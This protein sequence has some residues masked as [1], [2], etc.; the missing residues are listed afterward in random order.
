MSKI[1]DALKA[2]SDSDLVE[3]QKALSQLEHG[4][5][6]F[7]VA[8]LSQREKAK[9]TTAYINTLPDSAFFHIE[10][11][12]EKDD[13]DKTVPRSLRHLPYKDASGEVSFAHVRNASQRAPQVKLANGKPLPES[14]VR[15]VQ[16]QARKILAEGRKG[17]PG[18]GNFG[19][20]GR[21]GKHGGSA[22]KGGGGG[23]R[24]GGGARTSLS[25]GGNFS[26]SDD[27]LKKVLKIV[28]GRSGR[29]SKGTAERILGADYPEGDEHQEWL[30]EAPVHEIAD[31][32]IDSY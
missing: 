12:G 29:I 23:G 30:N 22:P 10:P 6:Y 5:E 3:L 21:P 14:I 4:G 25:G 17:G 2:C 11:G 18:S 8:E 15:R 13:D 27:R 32:I 1:N 16:E 26:I 20:A 9:W 7:V 19:H 28:R 24:G 31:W